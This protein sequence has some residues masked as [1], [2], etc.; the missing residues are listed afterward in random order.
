MA[1]LRVNGCKEAWDSDITEVKGAE[2]PCADGEIDLQLQPFEIK[3]VRIA[4]K[5][6]EQG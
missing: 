1:T 2:L 4:R 3:T 5:P 6:K